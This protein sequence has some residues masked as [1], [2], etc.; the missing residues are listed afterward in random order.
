MRRGQTAALGSSTK[1]M[2]R[3]AFDADFML[4]PGG[5]KSTSA[6][7]AFTSGKLFIPTDPKFYAMLDVLAPKM[8]VTRMSFVN[9]PEVSAMPGFPN[10]L[11]MDMNMTMLMRHGGLVGAT[12]E[13]V[14]KTFT[15]GPAAIV[16]GPVAD[17]MKLHVVQ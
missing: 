13:Q 15:G 14:V 3:N 9:V 11:V 6:M 8:L 7:M 2:V 4:T 12:K 17:R 5:G 10:G 16:S 1:P